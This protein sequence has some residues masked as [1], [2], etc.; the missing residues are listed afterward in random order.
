MCVRRRE[1]YFLRFINCY[2]ATKIKRTILRSLRIL[3]AHSIKI[4]NKISGFLKILLTY[5]LLGSY[6]NFDSISLQY[7]CVPRAVIADLHNGKA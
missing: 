6:I 1:M 3:I 2:Y 5:I 4:S 7:L